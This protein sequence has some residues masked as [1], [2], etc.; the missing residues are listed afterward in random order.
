MNGAARCDAR[1]MPRY[2]IE[3]YAPCS[4][5]DDARERARRA[6]ELATDVRYVRTTFLPEDETVLHMFD[7]PSA[8]ALDEAG[9]LAA[10]EYDRIVEAVEG[11]AGSQRKTGYETERKGRDQ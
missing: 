7:A 2:L 1:P 11:T 4:P 3:S 8:G 9:R 5:L 6:A 10:L